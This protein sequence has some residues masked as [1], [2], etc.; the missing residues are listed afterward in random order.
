LVNKTII[1]K[2]GC[3]SGHVTTQHSRG[4]SHVMNYEICGHMELY[5]ICCSVVCLCGQTIIT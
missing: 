4:V 2:R 5:N 3:S 1:V